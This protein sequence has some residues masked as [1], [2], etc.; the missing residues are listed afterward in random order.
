MTSTNGDHGGGTSA[1]F[2]PFSGDPKRLYGTLERYRAMALVWASLNNEAIRVDPNCL[3]AST[4]V[5][6]QN[7][8]IRFPGGFEAKIVIDPSVSEKDFRSIW[9]ELLKAKTKF[10]PAQIGNLN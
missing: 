9:F 1:R 6:H 5:T 7:S 10:G 3:F 2:T 8:L 4:A